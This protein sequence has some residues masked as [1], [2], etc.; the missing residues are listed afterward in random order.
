MGRL[1]SST[2][3]ELKLAL[4]IVYGNSI[5]QS[6]ANYDS[7]GRGCVGRLNDQR[8]GADG[9]CGPQHKVV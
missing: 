2:K 1:D 4:S 7:S 8:L 5:L 9:C 3:L 6:I